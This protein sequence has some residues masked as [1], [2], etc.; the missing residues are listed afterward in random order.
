[1]TDT[2]RRRRV[3]LLCCSFARNLA[4]YRA[5]QSDKAL[6]LLS[7][8]HPQASFWRQANA[9][10]LDLCVLEW[11][12]LFADRK[13]EHLWSRV[14]S[15]IAQFKDGLLR[16]VGLDAH[17]FE[18]EIDAMRLYRDKFVAHL[19]DLPVMNIPVLEVAKS[20]VWFYHGHV[21]TYEA[22]AG[23]LA[24]IPADSAA[25]LTCGYEQCLEEAEA[26][27]RLFTNQRRVD[28]YQE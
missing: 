15:D 5:G 18:G 13:G 25:K 12:K 6:T 16:H 24:G 23:E 20:A 1:M 7:A 11:C 8:T 4:F 9:N 21:V 10:F 17:A 28:D 22:K 26:V 19:D 14:V 27:I 2:E 3:V